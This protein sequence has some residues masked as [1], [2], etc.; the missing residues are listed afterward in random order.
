MRETKGRVM[1][2]G[3]VSG[4]RPLARGELAARLQAR[5]GEI[6][7]A[8][9]TRVYG[10][11]DPTEAGDPAYLDG[12]KGAV[13]AA[14][15]FGLDSIGS[16]EQNPPQ[17]PPEILIQARVAA[18]TGVSLDTVLRR[19]F[20]G[21]ALLGDFLI[22]EAEAGEMLGGDSLKRL[23]R[24]QASIFDRL[25]AAVSEE[26]GKEAEQRLETTAERRLDLVQRLLAGERLDTAELPYDI[27]ATHLGLV[28]EGD[29][30]EGVIREL[31]AVLDRRLLL[32][33]HGDGEVWAWLGGRNPLDREKL[34]GQLSEM[35][36]QNGRLALGES[37]EGFRGWRRS[38]QQA[39][40][41]LPVALRGLEP[42]VCYA[43]VALL[44]SMLQDDLLTT[45]LQ[46][47]YLTPLEAER[48]GGEMARGTLRAYFAA[49]R[50]VASAAAALGVTR[51]TVNNRLRAIEE[52]IGRSLNCCASEL[53]AAL[54]LSEVE[55]GVASVAAVSLA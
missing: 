20:A 28:A 46:Q 47:I 51:Q 40:A 9:L 29:S 3:L 31:A 24:V 52:R 13:A 18:R 14:I 39:R 43:D 35:A 32:V 7:E 49:E 23:L 48:D 45:S 27:E 19:Y 1:P 53:E 25:L 26:H 4:S 5:R 6:E 30:V 38:H 36:P 15:S 2:R 55:E 44:A 37:G 11:S 41:A 17:I 54:N 50:N 16:S 34:T 10:V 22:E 42:S 21:Y 12:L 8:I 33:R